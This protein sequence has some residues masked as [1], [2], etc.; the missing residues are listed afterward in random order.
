[1]LHYFNSS[2]TKMSERKRKSNLAEERV[3]V[4]KTKIESGTCNYCYRRDRILVEGKP[5]CTICAQDSVEC[6]YCHRP[7]AARLINENGKCKACNTKHHRQTSLSGAA[8]V[9]DVSQNE[10]ENR[11][12]LAYLSSAKEDVKIQLIDK[13]EQCKGVRWWLVMIVRMIKLDKVGEE[14]ETD[15]FFHSES[16]IFLL[17]SDYNH[18]YEEQISTITRKIDEFVK[19]GSGWTVEQIERL[20]V[21][22]APYQPT[23]PSSYIPTPSFIE[24]KKAVLNI[25]NTDELCFLWSVLAKLYPAKNNINN[26]CNYRSYLNSV[27]VTGLKF[28]LNVTD[29]KKFEKLNPTISVKVLAY[30]AWTHCIYPVHVT[31]WN[32]RDNHVNLLLLNDE[33]KNKA[34][35]ILI[36]SMSRLLSYRSKKKAAHYYCDYCL[37][38]FIR[39]DLLDNHIEDCKQFGVQKVV[40]PNRNEDKWVYY[41]AIE[42]QLP[43]PMVM[44][45]DFE[46]FTKKIQKATNPTAS[47]DPYEL[48]EPSGYA[49]YIVCS[50]PS[51]YQPLLECYHGPNVITKF[52]KRLR[53]EYEK[54]EKLLSKTEPMKQLTNEEM[55]TYNKAT[56]CYLCNKPLDGDKV[57]D[58]D[59][60]TGNYRGPAHRSCN[61]QLKYRGK[62]STPSLAK[63]KWEDDGYMV[64]VIFH[65]LRGY[66]GHL[67]MKGFRKYI[68]PNQKI[69]CIPNNMERYLSFTIGNLRFIDSYQFMSESLEKLASN[70][71]K[72]DFNHTA[73]QTPADKLHLLL[74]KGVFPYEYWDSE[75][76]FYESQLPPKSAFYCKLTG[77]DI[78]DDDYEHAK[79]VWNEFNIQHLVEYHDLYLKTDVLLLCDVFENFRKC[80]LK[81]YGLDPTHYYSA[82][83]M[84]W[85]AMLKMTGIKLEL[86][87]ER[88]MHNVIDKGT[89]GGICCISKKYARANNPYLPETYDA[90]KPSNYLLYLD[91]NNLYGTAMTQPLPEKDFTF[92][93]ADEMKKFDYN[94]VPDD[95][96]IGYILEVDLECDDSLHDYYND[97]PL[98]P[99]NTTITKDDL[100]SYTLNL[101]EKLNVKVKPYQKLVCNLKSKTKYVVHYRNLKLYIRLGM[102][103]TKIHRV[104]SFTQSCWLK[105]YIDFNT[106]MR[107]K[108]SSNFEKNFFKLMN[109]SVFGKTMENVR[110]HLDVK[111]VSNTWWFKKL[112]SKPN[113]KSFKIFTDDLTAVHL[114]KEQIILNKPTYVGMSILELSKT[115]MFSFHYDHIKQFYGN[116][117]TLLMTDTDS[118]VYDIQTKDVYDDIKGNID[119]YD[120][121]DYPGTHV[122]YNTKNKKT[123]GKMKDETN[124]HPIKEFVGLR[125]KMYSMMLDDDTEKKTAKGINKAASKKLKHEAYKSVLFTETSNVIDSVQIRQFKH[126]VYTANIRKVGLSPFDDKRYVLPD[127]ITTLAHGHAQTKKV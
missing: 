47:V 102:R 107:K 103:V 26:T 96:P 44:Y 51:K 55:L 22:I 69:K 10:T 46:S 108:A 75:E 7:L 72:E 121:S 83:G 65:N 127:K 70:I 32:Q 87:T 53:E 21:S 58:H 20:E 73:L 104:L 90:S 38:G 17:E 45:A 27:N 56:K 112:T 64:P 14:I 52:L 4:K 79:N 80:C 60:L 118:L 110:K 61:L 5:Y 67:I 95:S 62:S 16:D 122:A 109:N 93:A 86:F 30:N 8:S 84:A 123:L 49:F 88:E 85:D 1:M 35:Y 120:T 23:S 98:A 25:K 50:D 11:D 89:R 97:Y 57:M 37:H 125:P 76:R 42:R 33:K 116:R 78:G 34:H 71:K 81:N 19:L 24:K 124:S 31:K 6:I 77:Q 13:L 66:D 126:V 3:S 82:P 40:M 100:S 18:Q 54:I 105:P 106:E 9:I 113:F 48:H 29:V 12:P 43:V 92:L 94:S 111:L 39:K 101:A 36:K 91:M 117:A 99:E 15:V 119:L 63:N 74:R 115:F 28:P 59:H 114:S 41:K 68:F 2:I